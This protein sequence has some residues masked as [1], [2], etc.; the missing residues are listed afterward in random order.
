M[1][2][3]RQSCTGGPARHPARLEDGPDLEAAGTLQGDTHSS[4]LIISV[5]DMIRGGDYNLINLLEISGN[6][7]SLTAFQDLRME[8]PRLPVRN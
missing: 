6:Y 1:A 2:A 3:G 4:T 8:T 7:R 5:R